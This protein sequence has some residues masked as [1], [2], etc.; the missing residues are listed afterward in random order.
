MGRR[1]YHELASARQ[2]KIRPRLR[3]SSSGKSGSRSR[4]NRTPVIGRTENDE[5]WPMTPADFDPFPFIP[6][7]HTASTAARAPTSV[8]AV[9]GISV[10]GGFSCFSKSFAYNREVIQ[11]VG[12]KGGLKSFS[13]PPYSKRLGC[14]PSRLGGGPL[15]RPVALGFRYRPRAGASERPVW[16]NTDPRRGLSAVR[17]GE[18]PRSDALKAS[19]FALRAPLCRATC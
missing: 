1:T 4:I 17:C 7:P 5:N 6:P 12:G 10:S 13:L 14:L 8:S 11:T 9:S 2:Q 3:Q 18:Q 15:T 16:G 19:D